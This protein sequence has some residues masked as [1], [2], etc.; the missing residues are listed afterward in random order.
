MRTCFPM[1]GRPIVG[2]LHQAFIE[3]FKSG[4]VC[5]GDGAPRLVS[6]IGE[7]V[8]RVGLRQ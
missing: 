4:G 5:A 8:G 2:M 7:N 1:A 3:F 6:K